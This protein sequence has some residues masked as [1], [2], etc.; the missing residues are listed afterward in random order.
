MYT[1]KLSEEQV[2][3]VRVAPA[4]ASDAKPA[5]PFPYP[6]GHGEPVHYGLTRRELFAAMAMQAWITG[7]CGGEVLEREVAKTAIGYADALID[8]LDAEPP[9]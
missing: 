3:A 9:K 7:P 2:E 1:L 6:G 4:V 5:F 8:A